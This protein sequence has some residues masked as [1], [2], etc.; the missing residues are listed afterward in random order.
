[1][2]KNLQEAL[3]NEYRKRFPPKEFVPGESPVRISGTVSDEQE[4]LFG[5]EAV[6]DSWWT[7][8]RFS[9]EFEEK[10][11]HL[12][13]VKYTS[14]VNSGSSANLVALT[15][16]TSPKLGDKRLKEG[17]EV[18]TVAA[19]F[20][21]TVNPIIQNGLVPVFVDVDLGTY[22]INIDGLKNAIGPKTRAIMI[23]HTLGNPFALDVI[24]D[25]CKKNNLWL[26]EDNCD[27]LGSK[28]NGKY[29]GTFGHVSTCSFY[30]AHHITMGEGG[31]VFTSDNLLNGIIRSV[32]DW[33]RDCYCK[34]G[35]DNTCGMRFGWQL[36]DLPFGYD[37]KY[38]YSEIGYNLKLTDIQAAIGVAQLGKLEGFIKKRKDNFKFLYDSLKKYEEYFILPK[39][40]EKAEP[41]WFGFLLTVR[42]EAPFGRNQIVQHLQ[43][44]NIATRYLFAGNLVKQPYFIDNQVK[45]R[46]VG[47]LDNTDKVMKNT[48]WIGCYP[49]LTEE[50]LSYVIEN[51]NDFC[52]N[53]K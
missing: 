51:F 50:M 38:I 9:D 53:F 26:V 6:L 10:M 3:V 42:E 27:A 17:D 28:Y 34:T 25:I 1:M 24:I 19:G 48:F 49:G 43:E 44:S 14:L 37:H 12:L 45:Y 47:D 8:G 11:N 41:S 15:A 31:A 16:L 20:P 35:H 29:T 30:P 40:E 2:D 32:R 21:S 13:G 52:K 18:I 5:V 7:E 46:V 23:A 39:W 22:N 33:G 4:V 36:G